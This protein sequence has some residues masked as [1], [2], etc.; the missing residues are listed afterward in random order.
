MLLLHNNGHTGSLPLS[1]VMHVVNNSRST[2]LNASNFRKSMH[3]LVD[4][5]YLQSMRYSNLSLGISL[6]EKGMKEAIY[7]KQNRE[8]DN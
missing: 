8:L 5:G 4:S 1:K 7:I 6:T 2:L 3:K